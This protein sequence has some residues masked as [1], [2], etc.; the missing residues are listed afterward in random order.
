MTTLQYVIV[1]VSNMDRSIA[2]YR[3]ILGFPVKHQSPKW[4][5]FGT[6][7]ITLALDLADP[8]D[9]PHTHATTPAGHSQIGLTVSNLEVFRSA[10]DRQRLCLFAAAERR[11][12]W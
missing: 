2:F 5:E 7:G 11:R 1:F 4:T 8:H 10:N 3:D 12:I 6:E 9:H